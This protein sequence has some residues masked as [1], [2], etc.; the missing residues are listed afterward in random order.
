M[1]TTFFLPKQVGSARASEILLTGRTVAAAEAEKIGLV[2][3]VVEPERLMGAA[4]EMART[5]LA[6]SPV[7]LR[8]TKE[9]LNLNLTATSLEAAIELENR[10]QSIC[11]C[12][13]ELFRAIEDFNKRKSG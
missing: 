6:K 5:M 11:C 9:A 13:P 3:R 7:G 8:L 2:S 1:G 12:T 10:N 4:M